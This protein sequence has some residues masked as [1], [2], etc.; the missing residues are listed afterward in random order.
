MHNEKD[1]ADKKRLPFVL[2]KGYQRE[3][4]VW[5][6]LYHFWRLNCLRRGN[7]KVPKFHIILEI[8]ECSVRLHVV[9]V[10]MT[11]EAIYKNDC[12]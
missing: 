9:L 12:H 2:E 7:G 11:T 6:Q 3:Y 4:S 8:G 1:A 5:R 10:A